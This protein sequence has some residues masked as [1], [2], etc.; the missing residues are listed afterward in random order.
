MKE[1]RHSMVMVFIFLVLLVFPAWAASLQGATEPTGIID[2]S[3]RL[4]VFISDLHLGP[5][6]EE[7][8]KDWLAI[9]DFRWDQDF[10]KF[11]DFI[12]AEG[13]NN[14]DLIIL[15]DLLELWQSAKMRCEGL[16]GNRICRMLDC[17][18]GNENLGCT[19][20]EALVRAQRIISSHDNV[21]KALGVF[22]KAKGG[23]NRIIILP[24]NHDA[25]LLYP[26]VANAVLAAISQA[27]IIERNCVI[28]GSVCIKN[29]GYW[30]SKDGLIFADHGHALD[31]ANSFDSWPRPFIEE[32]GKLYLQRPFGEQLVQQYYNT[33]EERFPIIDNLSEESLGIRLGIAAEG[34]STFKDIGRFFKFLTLQ[35]SWGQFAHGLGEEQAQRVDWDIQEIRKKNDVNFLI[36]S[37]DPNDPIRNIAQQAASEGE[38]NVR[39]SDLTCEEIGML[40]DYRAA[41]RS[42]E[43]RQDGKSTVTICPTKT[44]TLGYAVDKILNRKKK[45]IAEHLSK[46]YD[47]VRSPNS[48]PFDF[49]L[50]GHTHHAETLEVSMGWGGVNVLNTGSF[51][52]VATKEQLDGIKNRKAAEIGKILKDKEIL[53]EVR[54]EDLPACY[55]FVRVDYN[56]GKPEPNLAC[57][58]PGPNGKLFPKNKCSCVK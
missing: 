44:E 7:G 8:G 22:A 48:K 12:A 26:K 23:T 42:K 15:G 58:I 16:K 36:D 1:N 45:N 37:M 46:S 32:K 6:K 4:T 35:L 40:C 10:S 33:Y 49:Y 53:P 25:S 21:F 3:K 27:D 28:Q 43:M 41:L 57:W 50:Y 38:I 47:L 34:F 31:K 17:E 30:L 20:E 13:K 39:P 2:E 51:Q 11:L 54:P 56:N 19:E 55:N 5:G 14:T 9:E 29:E 52:R 24:G 18:H